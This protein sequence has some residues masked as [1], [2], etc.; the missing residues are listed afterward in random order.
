VPYLRSIEAHPPDC[1]RPTGGSPAA[2]NP[3]APGGGWHPAAAAQQRNRSTSS[4]ARR[5]RSATSPSVTAGNP[6]SAARIKCGV[7]PTHGGTHERP[8]NSKPAHVKHEPKDLSGVAFLHR[9]SE[10]RRNSQNRPQR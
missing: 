2:I 7:Q 8:A 9:G 4:R 6:A 5:S 10:P 3:A 1:R